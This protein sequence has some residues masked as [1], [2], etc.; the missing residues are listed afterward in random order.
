[1]KSYTYIYCCAGPWKEIETLMELHIKGDYIFDSTQG[2]EAVKIVSL[3]IT[4]DDDSCYRTGSPP[5]DTFLA[6]LVFL[7][8][9]ISAV[10]KKTF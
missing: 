9:V 10:D 8:L 6:I 2:V 7:E 3:S 5:S 1:M 4:E